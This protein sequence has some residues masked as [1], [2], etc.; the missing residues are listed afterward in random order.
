MGILLYH[1]KAQRWLIQY[2][3]SAQAFSLWASGVYKCLGRPKKSDEFDLHHTFITTTIT[4][5]SFFSLLI[6]VSS[7]FWAYPSSFFLHGVPKLTSFRHA[8]DRH[9]GHHLQLRSFSI[10]LFQPLMT[11][12]SLL[13][14][15][16]WVR[17]RPYHDLYAP[18]PTFNPFDV[19]QFLGRQF[20]FW[21]YHKRYVIPVPFD[22]WA[23]WRLTL[24]LG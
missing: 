9:S 23:I 14:F 4:K 15:L 7:V 20:L 3:E 2:V 18:H 10:S 13:V 21:K 17:L 1:F 22:C 6:R 11:L 5:T 16:W 12:Q 19:R 24:S 8:S